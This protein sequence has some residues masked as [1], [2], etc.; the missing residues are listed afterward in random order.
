MPGVQGLWEA[1]KFRGLEAWL[2]Y[3][4]PHP[5][6]RRGALCSLFTVFCSLGRVSALPCR[7]V[8]QRPTPSNQLISQSAKIPF[9]SF[10]I[11]KYSGSLREPSWFFVPLRVSPAGRTS[12]TLPAPHPSRAC[13]ALRSPWPWKVCG[14]AAARSVLRSPGRKAPLAVSSPPRR[15]PGLQP[16]GLL[17]ASKH[18]SLQTSK[19]GAVAPQTKGPGNPGPWGGMEEKNPY[20]SPKSSS[21][22]S[23]PP[24][25]TSTSASASMAV[26]MPLESGLLR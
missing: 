6:P 2:F 1:W 8:G 21:T 12:H 16:P 23:A 11:S 25:L 26:S 19:R 5:S 9:V 18:P 24:S 17:Q 14:F 13:R 20:R 7:G 22:S 10:V 15:R 4:S 3:P